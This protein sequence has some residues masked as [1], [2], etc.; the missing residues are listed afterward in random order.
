VKI[1]EDIYGQYFANENSTDKISDIVEKAL[2]MYFQ[3]NN[4]IRFEK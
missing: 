1:D 2:Q 3:N 4:D